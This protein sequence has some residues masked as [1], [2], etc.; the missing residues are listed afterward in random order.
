MLSGITYNKETII[1]LQRIMRIMCN[2][3]FTLCILFPITLI[4][5]LLLGYGKPEGDVTVFK[6]CAILAGFIIAALIQ[7]KVFLLILNWV[8]RWHLKK[9]AN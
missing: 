5:L 3:L 7:W 9:I 6:S 8:I 2:V 1:R 4:I